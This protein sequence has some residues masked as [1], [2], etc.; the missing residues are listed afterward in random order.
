MKPLLPFA[1]IIH[2]LRR[3]KFNQLCFVV[4]MAVVTLVD[5]P[6]TSIG[7]SSIRKLISVTGTQQQ[8]SISLSPT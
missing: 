8:G 6:A 3:F 5:S 2:M 4:T 7:Y 1:I